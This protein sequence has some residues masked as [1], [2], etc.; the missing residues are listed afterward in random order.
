MLNVLYYV[1]SRVCHVFGACLVARDGFY[2]IGYKSSHTY[3]VVV[4][5]LRKVWRGIAYMQI[6]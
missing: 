2:T 6:L 5:Y 1:L 4:L 3:D